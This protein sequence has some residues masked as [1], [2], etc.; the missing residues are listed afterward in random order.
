MLFRSRGR[1]QN[2]L[3][4]VYGD[5]G[6]AFGQHEGNFGHTFQVYEENVHV[7]L[8]VAMPGIIR[9]TVRV[10]RPVSLIDV[11]ATTM[12]LVA[13]PQIVGQG[14]TMLDNEPRMALFFADYSLPLVGLRDG[15]LKYI[16]E[17]DSGR[18]RLFDVTAD[19]DERNDLSSTYPAETRRYEEVLRRWSAAQKAAVLQKVGLRAAAAIWY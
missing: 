12:D 4:I 7:P 9:E 14:R 18:D 6:E 10:Q 8:A 5:H 17:L 16:Y 15:P 19:P 11:A 13:G 1:Q 2:T 3:W